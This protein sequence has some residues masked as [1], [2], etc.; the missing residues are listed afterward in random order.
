ML[1]GRRKAPQGIVNSLE[2]DYDLS[3][4]IIFDL[5][6]E[7]NNTY[8]ETYIRDIYLFLFLG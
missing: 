5:I 4:R 1:F 6:I 8:W 3:N 2:Q 7:Y